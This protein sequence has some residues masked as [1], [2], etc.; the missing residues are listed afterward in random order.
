MNDLVSQHRE[1]YGRE[2]EIVAVA[3]GTVNILGEHTDLKAGMP[4]D[5][6]VQVVL[7]IEDPGEDAV[8]F[9]FEFL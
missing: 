9:Q 2:P 4:V 7:E 6:P 8:S 5:V 1:E 3:P